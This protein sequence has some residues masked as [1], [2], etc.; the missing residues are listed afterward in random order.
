MSKRWFSIQCTMLVLFLLLIGC[1]LFYKLGDIGITDDDEAWHLANA[2]DMY[3]NDRWLINTY[4]GEVDY[5][6]S[7][8]PLALW[9]IIISFRILGVSLFAGKL[10][11][12]ITGFVICALLVVF[13]IKN[14]GVLCAVLF[15]AAFFSFD[16]LYD[17]HMFRSGDLDAVFSLFFILGLLFLFHARDNSVWLI[18]FGICLGLSFLSKSF[19]VIS[20]IGV[21]IV[22]LPFCSRSNLFRNTLLSFSSMV[23]TIAPW[24]IKRYMFDKAVFFHAMFFGE[25]VEKTVLFTLEFIRTVA[26]QPVFQL[27]AISVI[28]NVI[29][30]VTKTKNIPEGLKNFF[31]LSKEY[32]AFWFGTIIPVALYSIAGTPYNWYIFPSFISAAVLAA[33]YT[34][35]LIS[36]TQNIMASIVAFIFLFYC[37]LMGCF[38]LKDYRLAG[39]GGGQA[40]EYWHDLKE[41]KAES[42]SKYNSADIYIQNVSRNDDSQELVFFHDDMACYSMLECDFHCKDGGYTAWLENPDSL[43]V[44]NKKLWDKYSNQLSGHYIICDNGYLFFS[45][46]FY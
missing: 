41:I 28:L 10:P 42:G 8:P 35:S 43:L 37:S 9:P 40:L 13:L 33:I 17:F 34:E 15:S 31:I 32:S 5:Y 18:P 44:L 11:S 21:G 2:Y 16:L 3:Q 24:A 27:L 20:L 26:V 14:R 4:N 46:A 19:H 30:A 38:Q 29:I 6:N 1:R 25:V 7:K 12:A 23:V 39:E 22:S 36:N 45:H